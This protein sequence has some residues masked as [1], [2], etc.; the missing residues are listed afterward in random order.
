M[1]FAHWLRTMDRVHDRATALV[2]SS[3]G[4]IEPSWSLRSREAGRPG[5]VSPNLIQGATL[6]FDGNHCMAV[7]GHR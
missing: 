3:G 1:R 2:V 6:T 7:E 5:V 4:S